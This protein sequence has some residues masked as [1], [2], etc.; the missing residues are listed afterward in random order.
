M[1]REGLLCLQPE[2]RKSDLRGQLGGRVALHAASLSLLIRGVARETHFPW[3]KLASLDIPLCSS[4]SS[5]GGFQQL[6][7][8][9]GHVAWCTQWLQGMSK[10]GSGGWEGSDVLTQVL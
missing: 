2:E 9:F 7:L 10:E 5:C 6:S 4:Y 3:Q 1:S 8:G